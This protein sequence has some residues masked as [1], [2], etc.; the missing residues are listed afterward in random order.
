MSG[1]LPHQLCWIENIIRQARG[2]RDRAIEL[3]NSSIVD[4]FENII[5]YAECFL[6]ETSEFRRG[7][8]EAKK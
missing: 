1:L 8:V 6:P 4:H 5:S 3:G 7:Y 2:G